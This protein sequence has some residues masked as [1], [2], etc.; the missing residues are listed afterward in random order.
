MKD[1]LSE[2]ESYWTTRAEGYSEVNHK[3]LI[4]MQKG[5]WLEVLKGQFP[6]KA[7]DEIKILD[8]GTGPGFFS[9]ILAEAGYKVTAVDYTQEMLDTAKRNAGNLCERISFYKMDA[10]NLEF[11]DDV[12]DVVISRNLTW[13]LKDPKRAY[14]EWCRVLKPG[15]KLLN[16]DANWYGYLYDEEKRLSYEEDRK[17]VESEHLDDHY[18]CT[19]IDRMEKIALQMPLSSINRPSWDRKFL[20]EN[21]FESVAVDTGIWQRVWS[22][23]EKLNYHSTPMFMISA[24]KEEKNVWSENDGMGD[25]DSG[26]DRKRDLK[27][28]MLCAAPGMKKSGFLRLGGGEFSLPYTVICGSHPGKTV[29]ITAAVH[30]GEYVGIQAAVELADKLKPEKIHGRVILVKTVCRKEFEERSGSVCPEDEKNLNRVFP[31]NP[32]GT[33]MD[34]LAYEVVQKLHS[35]ADYYIDLHSG[36]DYEQ[37][38]P[39]IY[40]AGC[41][42]EDVV[43]M[44]RKMAEQADVPYMVKSNVASGGSYNYAAACGIPSVLIER[45]QMGSWSPEEVHSTRKDVRNILCALGIYDGMRS[46]SNYYPMEIEDVRY[47]SASVSGLWYPAKKPGDI[48][49]QDE[50]LGEIRDYE[51]NVQEICRADMDGV[52]LYQVSS[53]QVVEGGPVITYGNIVREKDERKTRIA[54]YWT[55]R[56]DSFLEQRR[57]ELHSA[58]A[59]RWMAELKKYLPEKKNLRILD[60]GCGTGFFTILLAKEGHQVTGIDLTPDMITHA[61]ELAEEEKA[62][63]RFMVMDAEAP[64]FPDEEFDVIVSRNLT[65]TLPDA[66]HAYQEWFRVLKPGG[67]MINLD[68]NYGAADFADTADLP[69]NHAHHQIQ[70]ELMQECEDIKRQ[71]PISS[72]LRPAWDLETLSRIGVEEFSFDLGISKRIYTEKDEFYNPT[73]M[74]LIFAKKQR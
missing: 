74:F 28:A 46:Y 20:K 69:E 24:V 40:Y 8:I 17:S 41:A 5:A 52:I 22:Q 59:G 10:Q 26:Y 63:C 67:V 42:D 38:T 14:E 57:A 45:G 6:E 66:E 9:V 31:G 12:F 70:D 58:L 44:S 65:W 33:R 36:D 35:A 39:Y 53:L 50:I 3:E 56:S 73:P 64:D 16:F 49:H 48:I 27:D 30:G 1:L 43:Q 61:K 7:K 18:L 2:I 71:L 55:R 15:G 13:N 25:S 34:R 54:Q 51:G 19:D 32:Q 21:G 60:V 11:E 29:L 23:E 4:G 72:F 37:L 47:Q 62:D 68:A